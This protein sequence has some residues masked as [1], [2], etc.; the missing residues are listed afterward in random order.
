M[1]LDCPHCVAEHTGFVFVGEYEYP[2]ARFT[3][4]TFFVCRQCWKGVVV[5]LHGISEIF[6]CPSKCPGDPRNE[7]FRVIAIHPK[8]QAIPVPEHVPDEIAKDYEE[9]MDNFK[10]R[11]W[12]S[13]GVM[14]RRALESATDELVPQGVDFKNKNLFERIGILAQ[15]HKITQAMGDWAHII[16]EKARPAAHPKPEKFDEASATQ[17]QSFTELFLIYA[18]TMPA[19]VEQ[20]RPQ[21]ESD[22]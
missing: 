17:M 11:N 6:N 16:R 10:R 13:A 9:G 5:V 1:V 15:H 2:R 3:W 14:F 20:A 18:F 19:R 21:A 22:T 8:P 12:N 4:N 7:G